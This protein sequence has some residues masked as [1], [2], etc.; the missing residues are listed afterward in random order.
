[1][2]L[3]SGNEQAFLNRL[4]AIVE[5]N[6]S[7]EK[8]GV[9]ELAAKTGLS[10]SQIHRRLKS[11][12]NKSV[13]QFIREIRLERSKEFLEVGNFTVS[14]V[15]YKVG[16]GS[17]SYFIKSFHDYFGY[18]PGE[19]KHQN[20][21]KVLFE[22]EMQSQ[23]T[24]ARFLTNHRKF[25]F[26]VVVIIVFLLAY[27]IYTIF[28][29]RTIV[30]NVERTILVDQLENLSTDNSNPYFVVG[31][32]NT[33]RSQLGKIPGLKVIAGP[34]SE[35]FK[36]STL[37]L[38]E[39]AR[40]VKANYI[41]TGSAQLQDNKVLINI[42]LI[43][44]RQNNDLW[45][46]RYFKE[47]DDFFGTQIDIA[48]NIAQN[49]QIVLS[50][51]EIDQIENLYP[52]NFEAYN[53]YL[54]GRYLWDRRDSISLQK[55]EEY[56]KKAIEID[57]NYAQAYA[58][59]ADTYYAQSFREFV[60]RE[61]G[62]NKAFELANHALDMDENLPEALAVLGI[63]NYFGFWK[64][65]EARKLFEKAHAIDPNCMEA[66]LYYCSFLDIVGEQDQA[67]EHANRAYE[68]KP[69]FHMPYVMKGVIYHNKKEYAKSTDAFRKSLELDSEGWESYPR[70]FFNF[71]NMNDEVSAV[72][73]LQKFF[74]VYPGYQKYKSEVIPVYKNS[75]LN[76]ILKLY[77]EAI[78]N[79][80]RTDLFSPAILYMKL[81]MPKE[82][83]HYLE[84]ACREGVWDVPR[85]IRIPE[86][87][88]LH[89]NPRFQALV[90][91]MNLR[92]YFSKPS[93]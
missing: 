77:L 35:Q 76:G 21:Q 29:I 92:P 43:N 70:I 51:K 67:L 66:H 58:G 7:N 22:N 86:F 74:S 72:Q 13:S 26:G 48:R 19:T 88:N 11:V 34:T 30:N 10:R 28:P 38:I 63:V 23:S 81:G 2:S 15:A 57:S 46:G 37:S 31:L 42:Y 1:M 60:K 6:L 71:L 89:S 64:W 24:Q 32:S 45:T 33:I 52:K 78:Q 90:D 9:N 50:P 5:A 14:E 59:L 54:L 8:F 68:L 56:F 17:P 40:Q 73:T 55:S 79:D 25:I 62:Y 41:L 3:N 18:P 4:T 39:I 12:C 82:A 75:G 83:L 85:M 36:D 61:S 65:E 53:N 27:F 69:F 16:F 20:Q 84:M 87:E 80:G 47:V 44:S 91:T 93:K 49:L